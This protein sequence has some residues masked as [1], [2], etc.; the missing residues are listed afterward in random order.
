MLGYETMEEFREQSAQ[1]LPE[2][3]VSEDADDIRHT[4]LSL[5]EEGECVSFE[6]RVY[7]KK[8]GIRWVTGRCEGGLHAGRKEADSKHLHGYN[9]QKARP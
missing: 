7:S 5:K 6:H 3:A 2:V 9:R 1:T 4:L 8:D